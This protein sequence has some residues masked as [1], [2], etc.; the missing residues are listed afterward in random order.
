MEVQM[1]GSTL[2]FFL[3]AGKPFRMVMV[4]NWKPYLQYFAMISDG[5]SVPSNVASVRSQQSSRGKMGSKASRGTPGSSYHDPN[6]T[7]PKEVREEQKKEIVKESLVYFENT[8]QFVCHKTLSGDFVSTEK[9][10]VG[11]VFWFHDGKEMERCKSAGLHP[12]L[13]TRYQDGQGPTISQLK[14]RGKFV[15]GSKND[16]GD[17]ANDQVKCLRHSPETETEKDA[18]IVRKSVVYVEG[19]HRFVDHETKNG[20]LIRTEKNGCG[21]VSWDYEACESRRTN[22]RFVRETDY[23]FLVRGPTIGELRKASIYKH[24]N[25]NIAS[26]NCGNY[27][28]TQVADWRWQGKET[29]SFWNGFWNLPE[30]NPDRFAFRIRP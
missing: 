29:R 9:D 23:G 16:S 20:L 18:E 19:V 4:Q 30:E 14:E 24:G 27:A 1:L 21:T 11:R 8:H 28:E 22:A 15:N 25:Y 13:W 17:Y 12:H 2:W 26:D 6:A 7:G 3:S 10:D 5:F